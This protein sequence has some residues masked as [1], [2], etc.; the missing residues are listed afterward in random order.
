VAAK[1]SAKRVD[2]GAAFGRVETNSCRG[3]CARCLR[4]RFGGDDGERGCGQKH[5]GED[6][7]A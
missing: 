7:S 1:A 2:D 5:R 6:F 3:R 4:A